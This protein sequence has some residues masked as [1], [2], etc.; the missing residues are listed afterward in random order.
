MSLHSQILKSGFNVPWPE[1]VC[2]AMVVVVV[3]MVLAA[4]FWPHPSWK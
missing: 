4:E 3:A 2:P 1:H